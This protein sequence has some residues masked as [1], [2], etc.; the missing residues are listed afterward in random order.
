[1]YQAADT[2]AWYWHDACRAEEQGHQ[3]TREILS[4]TD[5]FLATLLDEQEELKATAADTARAQL[6]GRER[7]SLLKLVIGMA[8]KGYTYKPGASKSPIPTEI[9][10]DLA[11]LGISLDVDTVRKWLKAGAELLPPETEQQAC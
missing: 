1:M 3:E 10:D 2:N 6:G 9:A 8:V 5:S 11:L 4:R 7:D